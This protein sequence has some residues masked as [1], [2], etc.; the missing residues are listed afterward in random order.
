MHRLLLSLSLLLPA[1]CA[2]TGTVRA[3]DCVVSTVAGCGTCVRGNVD[4]VG[5]AARFSLPLALGV[6][7]D[8]SII[9]TADADNHNIRAIS[10]ATSNVSTLFSWSAPGPRLPYGPDSIAV[11]PSGQLFITNATSVLQL[12]PGSPPTITVIGS[13]LVNP[14]G[15]ALDPA[16]GNLYIADTDSHCI[17]IIRAPIAPSAALPAAF[18]GY[19]NSTAIGPADGDPAA[20]QGAVDGDATSARF[21]SPFGIA[22]D[23]ARGLLAVGDSGNNC[24]RLVSLGDGSVRTLAGNLTAA[25]LGRR[26]SASRGNSDGIGAAA[27]FETPSGVAVDPATGNVWV[28]DAENHAIRIVYPTGQSFTVAG[29]GNLTRGT[30]DGTGPVARFF[31]PLGVTIDSARGVVYVADSDNH[32]VRSLVCPSLLPPSTGGGGNSPL[33][34]LV[35]AIPV[36]G[37]VILL[38]GVAMLGAGGVFG[39]RRWRAAAGGSGSPSSGSSSPAY[40]KTSSS[41]SVGEWASRSSEAGV[42]LPAV[43]ATAVAAGASA[44]PV[45]PAAGGTTVAVPNPLAQF[46]TGAPAARP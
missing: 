34:P 27:T 8:S 16:T 12:S 9:W 7:P 31:F 14:Q 39:V 24:V 36:G 5:S 17:R 3:G 6:A 42:A 45:S 19:C 2:S 21:F 23:S 29:S 44:P 22:V 40:F 20:G 10:V 28:T 41:H 30:M 32:A 46:A 35:G 1:P 13:G 43:G 15:I 37:L 4:G 33:G 38:A 11:S 26:P 18:S 25:A